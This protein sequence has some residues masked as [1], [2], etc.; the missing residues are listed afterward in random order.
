MFKKHIGH[1][2]LGLA[3]FLSI[4]LAISFQAVTVQAQTAATTLTPASSPATPDPTVVALQ[5]TVEAQTDSLD[6]LN[7]KLELSE[8]ELTIVRDEMTF[9]VNRQLSVWAGIFVVVTFALTFLGFR[10]Y[11]ELKTLYYDTMRE[12]L[13]KN[14]YQLDPT[15][16]PILIPEQ[17]FDD[18]LARIRLSGL[19]NI[20][21]YQYL[22]KATCN[23][24]VI[25]RA[26]GKQDE[27]LFTTFIQHYHPKPEQA[28]YILYS[29]AQVHKVSIETFKLY[30]NLTVATNP[31]A[32]ARAI[33]D[34]GRGLKPEPIQTQEA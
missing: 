5:S 32:L 24:V 1:L 27:E 30:N 3:I 26:A 34:V 21:P 2:L 18:E 22:G 6:D 10:S 25:V 14:L 23:G 12:T 29:P 16:L 11:R 20:Q 19:K 33:L 31:T 8:R 4:P 17:G 28:A 15:F 9:Q 7:R 13:Q